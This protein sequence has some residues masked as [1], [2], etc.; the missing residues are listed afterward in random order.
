MGGIPV[1]VGWGAAAVALEAADP[2]ACAQPGI[3]IQSGRIGS[4][5]K[6]DDQ[7]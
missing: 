6:E 3:Q 5:D 4:V 7:A 2:A 1:G